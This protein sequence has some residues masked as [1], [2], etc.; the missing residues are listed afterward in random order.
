MAPAPFGAAEPQ[1]RMQMANGKWQAHEGPRSDQR[2]GSNHGVDHGMK[3]A[4]ARSAAQRA[5]SLR[6]RL[7]GRLVGK[8]AAR[9]VVPSALLVCLVAAPAHASDSLELMPD[10]VVTGI[11][12]VAFILLIGPL[13]AL[14]FRPLLKVMDAR[15]DRI[16][17][18]RAR[19]GHVEGQASETLE[20]YEE[21]IL[22]AREEAVTHRRQQL[23]A[24]RADLLQTTRSAKEEAERELSQARE[25]LDASIGDARESLRASAQELAK[26][27]AE[28]VLGRSLS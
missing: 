17:G 18:A 5:H 3:Q 1:A 28:R 15:E 4:V 23:G 8:A 2:A 20:R 7:E 22:G 9:F 10:F 25:E 11:L 24:A 19:A 16:A 13:N 26:I 27:S 6:H 12:L 21:A 14:I